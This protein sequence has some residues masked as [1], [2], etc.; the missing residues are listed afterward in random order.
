[1][2]KKRDVLEALVRL[3]TTFFQLMARQVVLSKTY[4][5]HWQNTAKVQ[6]IVTL[7]N[8]DHTRACQENLYTPTPGATPRGRGILP[9]AE[10]LKRPGNDKHLMTVAKKV[11]NEIMQTLNKIKYYRGSVALRVRLGTFLLSYVQSQPE[12][13]F[14]MTQFE[15]MMSGSESIEGLVTQEYVNH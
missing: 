14:P 4:H 7:R 11:K 13:G 12:G 9:K 10:L 3:R 1:M 6:A 15:A 2:G 8:Y 5:L